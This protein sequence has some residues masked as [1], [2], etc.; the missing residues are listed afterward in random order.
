MELYTLA[1]PIMI[2]SLPAADHPP[3]Q[4]MD[5]G[6]ARSCSASWSPPS[7]CS[8]TSCRPCSSPTSR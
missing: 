8:S 2:V 7:A 3:G 1:N 4:E 6:R 5:A